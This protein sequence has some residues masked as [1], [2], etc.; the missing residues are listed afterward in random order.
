MPKSTKRDTAIEYLT[1][2]CNGD[3]NGVEST[4]GPA[5]SLTG[6]LFEFRSRAEYISSLRNDPPE[7]ATLELIH[8][9]ESSDTVLVY[10]AYGKSTGTITIAQLFKFKGDKIVNTLLVF[11]SAKAS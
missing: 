2:F 6:P 1:H 5:F 7:P 4:L 10:Y 9:S 11:D 3:I 8:V